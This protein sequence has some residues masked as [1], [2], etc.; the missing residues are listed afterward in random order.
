M[1]EKKESTRRFQQ[2]FN[3]IKNYITLI[4]LDNSRTITFQKAEI[5]K[6]D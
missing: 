5:F 3:D 1:E 2:Y 4:I 6:N